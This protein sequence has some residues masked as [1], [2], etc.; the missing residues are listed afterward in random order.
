MD[1]SSP[2]PHTWHT[3]VLAHTQS[4]NQSINQSISVHT[5]HTDVLAAVVPSLTHTLVGAWDVVTEL[6]HVCTVVERHTKGAL[7]YVW[8]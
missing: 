1:Q 4:I 7:V 5:W 3:D 6:P 2:C 8:G